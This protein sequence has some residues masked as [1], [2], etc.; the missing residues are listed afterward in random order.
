[1]T[2]ACYEPDKKNSD[3]NYFILIYS[4]VR[5]C[6]LWGSHAQLLSGPQKLST[7]PVLRIANRV[8]WKL[9]CFCCVTVATNY[10]DYSRVT[11]G[12]MDDKS[13]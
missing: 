2:A 10:T 5:F 13:W 11:Y 4:Q 3:H 7:D 8:R 6:L 1:L 9:N 12:Q